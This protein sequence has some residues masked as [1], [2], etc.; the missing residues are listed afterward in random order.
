MVTG[1]NLWNAFYAMITIVMVTW[2][3][4][5]ICVV[6]NASRNM[7]PDFRKIRSG[8]DQFM[9]RLLMLPSSVP[10]L[11][12]CVAS[13]EYHC[14]DLI[15]S[16]CQT[17]MNL[18]FRQQICS[19]RPSKAFSQQYGNSLSIQIWLLNRAEII[20]AGYVCWRYVAMRL[21]VG[22]WLKPPMIGMSAQCLVNSQLPAVEIN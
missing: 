6:R 12:I 10:Y 4:V 13:S 8:K 21:H 11:I 1:T 15:E 16:E 7:K 17:V 9:P 3:T 2:L 14:K 19:R 18:S 22:K 5:S 20:V